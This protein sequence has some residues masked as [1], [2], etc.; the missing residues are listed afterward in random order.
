MTTPTPNNIIRGELLFNIV[1]KLLL[2]FLFKAAM[3]AAEGA[4]QQ[5]RRW[6]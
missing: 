3:I 2:P 1:T 4:T 6:E 5:V